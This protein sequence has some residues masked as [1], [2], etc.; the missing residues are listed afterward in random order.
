MVKG[1]MAV[2]TILTGYGASGR[3]ADVGDGE[4]LIVRSDVISDETDRDLIPGGVHG[5]VL[6]REGATQPV[7]TARQHRTRYRR[8]VVDQNF[9]L[10][11]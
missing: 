6:Q 5:L 7:E 4:S 11:K 1:C 8:P 10:D 3:I 9:I 2:Q